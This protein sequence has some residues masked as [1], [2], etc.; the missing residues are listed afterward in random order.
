LCATLESV[1]DDVLSRPLLDGSRLLCIKDLVIHV[2]TL[3]DFWIHEDILRHPPLRKTVPALKDSEW[4]TV[5]AGFALKTLLDYWRVR[6]QSTLQ[7]PRPA[8]QCSCVRRASNRLG[9]TLRITC[10]SLDYG[11]LLQS[12]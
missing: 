8:S 5:Y 9:L 3:E 12:A 4:G 2:P 1:P 10:H 7:V 11:T 6:E